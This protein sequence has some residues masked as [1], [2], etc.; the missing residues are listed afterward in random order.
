MNV[1]VKLVVGSAAKTAKGRLR[2]GRRR[3]VD[4]AQALQGQFI[5][6]G[7]E[8]S[9]QSEEVISTSEQ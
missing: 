5:K 2:R 9:C 6:L 3:E 4:A 7:Y 8:L 1:V